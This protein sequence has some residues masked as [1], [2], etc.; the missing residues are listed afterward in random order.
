VSLVSRTARS[1]LTVSGESTISKLRKM[2]TTDDD[3]DETVSTSPTTGQPAWMTTLASN[4]QQWLSVLPE[5]LSQLAN[6]TTP[7][8]RFFAREISTGS[9]LLSRIRKELV[10]LVGALQGTIKQT[11]EVRSLISDLNKGK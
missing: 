9:S 3:A 7:L 6:I 10:E 5:A 2:C 1:K 4:A 8:D 11:N